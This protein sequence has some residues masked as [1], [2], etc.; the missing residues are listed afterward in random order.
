M[1]SCDIYRSSADLTLA[2][3]ARWY[4]KRLEAWRT[5]KQPNIKCFSLKRSTPK[6]KHASRT[7]PTLHWLKKLACA[8]VSALSTP[9]K[10]LLINA[11]AVPA[12]YATPI[13]GTPLFARQAFNK[14]FPIS[15][16]VRNAPFVSIPADL[17]GRGNISMH[18]MWLLVSHLVTM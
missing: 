13:G 1:K 3:V 8:N 18:Q 15:M 4:A 14:Q 17:G 6:E 7:R 12:S 11:W 2:A 5:S 16:K 9:M 10:A